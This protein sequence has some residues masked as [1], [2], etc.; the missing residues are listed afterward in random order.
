MSVAWHWRDLPTHRIPERLDDGEVGATGHNSDCC[1]KFGQGSF[2][3]ATV[4]DGLVLALKQGSTIRGNVVPSAT[5]SLGQFQSD[6]AA[7]RL[8]WTVDEG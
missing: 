8:G 4:A 5:V 1:W 3:V 6:L 2:S 7:T